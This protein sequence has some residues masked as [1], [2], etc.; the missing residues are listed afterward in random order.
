[1]GRMPWHW[2]KN[3]S[4]RV[5]S[6]YNYCK[7]DATD[8]SMSYSTSGRTC[9]KRCKI[10]NAA[11]GLALAISIASTPVNPSTFVMDVI[12]LF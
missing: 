12:L 7:R 10:E 5:S 9:Y 6:K 4:R 11:F 8:C 1:M 2:M 3:H